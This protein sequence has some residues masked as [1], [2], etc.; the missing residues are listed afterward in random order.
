MKPYD[1]HGRKSLTSKQRRYNYH[2]SQTRILVECGFGKVK[3]RFKVLHE[4]TD[5]RNH[6]TNARMI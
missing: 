1:E 5:R 2:L 4:L 3:A 6:S